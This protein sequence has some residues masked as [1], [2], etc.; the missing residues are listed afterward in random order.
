MFSCDGDLGMSSSIVYL[1][2]GVCLPVL[3]VSK[4][5]RSTVLF[6]FWAGT[7]ALGYDTL[8]I[9]LLCSLLGI[10]QVLKYRCDLVFLFVIYLLF[11]LVALSRARLALQLEYPLFEIKRPSNFFPILISICFIEIYK[12]VPPGGGVGW[13]GTCF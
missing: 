8:H 7:V 4:V 11:R 5:L 13:E 2:L 3:L 12:H 6:S 10:H 9:Y 1:F